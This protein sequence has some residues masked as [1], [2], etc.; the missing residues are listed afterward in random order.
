MNREGKRGRQSDRWMTGTERLF[1]KLIRGPIHSS[2]SEL[3]LTK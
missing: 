2:T 1:Q 3:E